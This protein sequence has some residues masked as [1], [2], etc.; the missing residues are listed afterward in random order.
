[1][2]KINKEDYP[3]EKFRQIV[4]QILINIKLKEITMQQ[5][6]ENMNNLKLLEIS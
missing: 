4:K 2:N 1:M 3:I 6:R 5:I